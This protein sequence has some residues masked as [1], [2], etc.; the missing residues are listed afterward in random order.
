M[1]QL[2]VYNY[3][4]VSPG[5]AA[6]A[7]IRASA[8]GSRA[9]LNEPDLS[10]VHFCAVEL[11]QSPLH[12]RVEPELYHPLVPPAF[13]GVGVSHLPRLP[14]VVLQRN[15]NAHDDQRKSDGLI[16]LLMYF[17]IFV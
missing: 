7:R 4:D 15:G 12:V 17:C 5:M 11:L 10:T 3:S 6:T 8:F 14:H 2:V 16:D 13:V 1:H 9:I